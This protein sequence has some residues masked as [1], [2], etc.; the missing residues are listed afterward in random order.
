MSKTAAILMLAT[1]RDRHLLEKLQQSIAGNTAGQPVHLL[2]VNQGPSYRFESSDPLLSISTLNHGDQLSLSAARNLGLDYAGQHQLQA[3][4]LMFPDDD[5]TFDR[6]FFEA[7]QKITTAGQAYLGRVVGEEDGRDYKKYPRQE[8]LRGKEELLA[9]V[10]SVSL[11]IPLPV[12]KA[13]GH[14]DEKL[15]AGARWASSEDLDYYLRCCQHSDFIY[16]RELRNFHPSRF[17]KYDNMDTQALKKRFASYTDGY[18][19]VMFRHGLER[20]AALLPL[21]AI[22]GAVVS[23]LRGSFRV[24]PIYLWLAAYRRKMY[25]KLAQK[26]NTEPEFFQPS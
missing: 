5:S 21:R 4:H 20:R 22:A 7:Y 8:Q 16:R 12:V 13:V 11:I 25:R 17:G 3:R 10:A 14:F 2:I 6:S 26:K 23:A 1:G 19:Y 24:V 9:F 15:G 18:L